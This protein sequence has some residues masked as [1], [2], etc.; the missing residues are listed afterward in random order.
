ML[1]QRERLLSELIYFMD[2]TEIEQRRRLSEELPTLDEYARCRMGTSA[3]S[4]IAAFNE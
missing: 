4:V 1:D 2:T 3:G